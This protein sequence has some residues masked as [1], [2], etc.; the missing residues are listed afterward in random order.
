M[1][2]KHAEHGVSHSS[3]WVYT[4][5][6]RSFH[7]VQKQRFSTSQAF[8]FPYR[9]Y[10]LIPRCA[11]PVFTVLFTKIAIIRWHDSQEDWQPAASIDDNNAFMQGIL[12]HRRNCATVSS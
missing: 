3:V 10:A 2:K 7:I 12:V 6:R 8:I 9:E 4:S 5:K 11:Y 1:R